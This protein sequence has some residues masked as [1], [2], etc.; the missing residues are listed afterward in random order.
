MENL[1]QWQKYC[2][3]KFGDIFYSLYPIRKSRTGVLKSI[4]RKVGHCEKQLV[5]VTNKS[6]GL[7]SLMTPWCL[8]STDGHQP[9]HE[10]MAT[11]MLFQG[12]AV[13]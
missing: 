10:G 7:A 12:V 6:L 9:T 8:F 4:N 2:C 11:D 1:S 3:S 5:N 13:K